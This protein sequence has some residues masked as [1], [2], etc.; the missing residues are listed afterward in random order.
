MP[1]DGLCAHGLRI[2]A[3]ADKDQNSNEPRNDQRIKA[4]CKAL[5]LKDQ[6]YVNDFAA[7]DRN[8]GSHLGSALPVHPDENGRS[9]DAEAAERE[10]N[11]LEDA[12]RLGNTDKNSQDTESGGHIARQPERILI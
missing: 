11:Q 7:N 1:S 4:K 9:P 6:Q 3:D 5:E 10:Q 2:Q 8:D 12:R